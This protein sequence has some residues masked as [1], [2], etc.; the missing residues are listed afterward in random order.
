MCLGVLLNNFNKFQ[1]TTLHLLEFNNKVR[2]RLLKSDANTLLLKNCY[3]LFWQVRGNVYRFHS[4][5]YILVFINLEL[6]YCFLTITYVMTV[7]YSCFLYKIKVHLFFFIRVLS[8][9]I[10]CSYIYPTF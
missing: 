9:M 1:Q 7:V 5:T 6:L 10:V 2:I 4:F 3:Y 8:K